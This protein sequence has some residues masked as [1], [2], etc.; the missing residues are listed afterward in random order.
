LVTDL[1]PLP[2]EAVPTLIDALKD[3]SMCIG[4]RFA[5]ER[6][7]PEAVP[8]LPQALEDPEPRVRRAVAAVLGNWGPAAREALPALREALNDDNDEVRLEVGSALNAMGPTN[9]VALRPV[10]L[11]D[12]QYR[13]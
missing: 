12:Q 3:D 2:K 11:E 5:L 4:A 9:G 8:A 1:E 10:L 13:V 6:V 7:G